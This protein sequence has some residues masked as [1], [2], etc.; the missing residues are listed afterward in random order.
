M[1]PESRIYA[2]AA[3]VEGYVRPSLLTDFA[4]E[5]KAL[6]SGTPDGVDQDKPAAPP[7]MLGGQRHSDEAAHRMP[8]Q[9]ER[10]GPVVVGDL[11]EIPDMAV[12]AVGA[13]WG[14]LAAATTA[15]IHR[16]HVVACRSEYGHESIERS[17]VGRQT[18]HAQDETPERIAVRLHVQGTGCQLDPAGGD[19]CSGTR[20]GRD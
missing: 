12:P 6:G 17:A 14:D 18:V 5:T 19:Q 2:S 13:G 15:Q 11:Q 7:R 20:S 1:V 10:I 8:D 9:V 4:M 16:D 3:G